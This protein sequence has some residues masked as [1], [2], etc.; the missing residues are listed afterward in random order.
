MLVV[1]SILT[2]GAG[3]C[4]PTDFVR[5][6]EPGAPHT[7]LLIYLSYSLCLPYRVTLFFLLQAQT[8]TTLCILSVCLLHIDTSF[9]QR[10]Q[11]FL[12][13]AE[14]MNVVNSNTHA[15]MVCRAQ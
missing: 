14:E 4:A 5:Q 6:V 15:N 12:L 2:L 13:S 9:V 10:G 8:W 7:P 3:A 1:L 11:F